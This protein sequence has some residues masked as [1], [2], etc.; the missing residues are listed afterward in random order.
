MVAGRSPHCRWIPADPAQTTAR[1][2]SNSKGEVMRMPRAE[3][4]AERAA[5]ADRSADARRA[6]I[7]AVLSSRCC[8]AGSALA[9]DRD[10]SR[11]DAERRRWRRTIQLGRKRGWELAGNRGREGRPD[12]SRG[13]DELDRPRVRGG[14][15][16]A[17][18]QARLQGGGRASSRSASSRC[19][20][21]PRRESACCATPSARYSVAE[22]EIRSYRRV[23]DLERRIY[24]I[25]HLRLNPSGVPVRGV[26]YFLA[27]LAG[28]LLAAR[29][30]GAGVLARGSRGTGATSSCRACWRRCSR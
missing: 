21:R 11:R 6:A 15:D 18:V 26:V 20:W 17:C 10:C 3:R 5:R 4:D 27:L 2:D 7:V 28:V 23:F 19:C 14:S 16:G 24:R 9:A 12:R 25:D 22:M 1:A 30:P 29:L 8:R 13:G